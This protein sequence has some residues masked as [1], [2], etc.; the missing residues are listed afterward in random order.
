MRY[1]LV[2]LVILAGC[3]TVGKEVTETQAGQFKRGVTTA[4]DVAEKL[5]APT[6]SGVSD[7]GS[8]TMSYVFAHAQPRAASF[9]PIVG[10]FAGGADGR[11]TMVTFVFNPDGKLAGY[12]YQQS[13]YGV[14]NLGTYQAQTPD[15]PREAK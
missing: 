13:A 7:S 11:T 5:G 12:S 14:S 1:L 4:A 6:S 15:Q 10:I 9:I 3:A 2:L 8:R